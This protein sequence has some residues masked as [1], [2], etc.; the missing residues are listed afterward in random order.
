MFCDRA[1]A[2]LV[3]SALLLASRPASPSIDYVFVDGYENLPDCSA[4]LTCATP[5]PGTFCIA[6]R[7]S[8]AGS[9]QPL[10][11]FI[12]PGA[13][14]GQGAVGGPCD[15]ELTAYDALEFANNPSGSPP[16]TSGER[17][18]DGCGRY[19][20]SGVQQPALGF[21]MVVADDADAEPEDLYVLAGTPRPTT[22]G[23]RIEGFGA[24]AARRDTV[25]RWTQSAGSPFGAS[26]FADVGVLL[27]V[28]S[29]GGMPQA[30]VVV[31]E[32]GSALP[33][34]DYYFADAPPARL[35]VD[36]ARTNTNANGAALYAMG[37][38]TDYS[39]AGAEPAGCTWA[40]ALAG[41]IAGVVV[42]A[43][44]EPEC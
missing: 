24:V 34:K 43:A 14:C 37:A 18:V 32:S 10:R 40:T 35:A 17:L 39:G 5:P 6:G 2:V 11:A 36:G 33:A 21:V 31:T 20:L 26:S 28:F 38:F 42:Y 29:V 8:E 30:G 27:L 1:A 19:R 3:G 13:V 22:A 4:D 23:A 16:L 9:G 12:N 25:A 41:T 44:L 7:V 15:V